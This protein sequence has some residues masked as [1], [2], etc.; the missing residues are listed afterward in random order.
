MG[1]WLLMGLT[2]E[3]CTAATSIFDGRSFA[4]WE[5]NTNSVWRIV[6][7]AITAGS[8][9]RVEPRNEF[10]ATVRQ[11]TNFQLRVR[12]KIQGTEALNAGVQFRTQRIPN[13]HEVSGYQAD[14]G[15]GVDGHLYDESR[16]N[17][18]LASPSKS[19]VERALRST[20]AEGWHEYRISA[21][22]QRILIW[23]NG[24]QMIEFNEPDPAIPRSGIIAL[25]IHGGMK[26]TIAYKDIEIEEFPSE[27]AAARIGPVAELSAPKSVFPS[28]RF[29]LETGDV[30][31]GFSF[32]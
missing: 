24:V 15:T 18:M 25:Q 1:V 29:T 5:G 10:L 20:S 9:D 30:L 28:R 31:I 2:A 6:N 8:F 4:G 11:Y 23:L 12:F 17:R 16:S 22:N 26:G 7:G 19:A 13:H 32:F 27:P 3:T 14:I 21:I